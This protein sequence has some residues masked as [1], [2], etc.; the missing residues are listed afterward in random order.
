MVATTPAPAKKDEVDDVVGDIEDIIGEYASFPAARSSIE[1]RAT[2][3]SE[4][5]AS[6]SVSAVSP[7]VGARLGI[8][9]SV[10]ALRNC[11]FGQYGPERIKKES[12]T[13]G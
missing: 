5:C 11:C 12:A 7:A 9:A 10:R 6:L 4:S 3:M 13:S 8:A 1:E 2:A